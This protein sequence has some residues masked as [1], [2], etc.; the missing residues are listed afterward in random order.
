M[1]KTL[2]RVENIFVWLVDLIITDEYIERRQIEWQEAD[3]REFYLS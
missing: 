1:L 2:T 3:E